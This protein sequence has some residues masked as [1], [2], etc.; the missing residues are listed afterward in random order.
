M[1]RRVV[2]VV[3]VV[4]RDIANCRGP[5]CMMAPEGVDMLRSEGVVA[6][7]FEAGLPEWRITGCPMATGLD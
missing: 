1:D 4:R 5:S 7:R 2:R 3:R 6:R